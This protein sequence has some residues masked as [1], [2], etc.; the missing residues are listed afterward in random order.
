M[1]TKKGNNHITYDR[2]T[3]TGDYNLLY[4][5][6]KNDYEQNKN[7]IKN[8]IVFSTD[9]ERFIMKQN[10]NGEVIHSIKKAHVPWNLML[11]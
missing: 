10:K 3:T 2:I 6:E 11:F 1:I 8:N 7:L 9:G 5:A 4:D